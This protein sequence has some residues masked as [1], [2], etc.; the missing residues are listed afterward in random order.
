MAWDEDNKYHPLSDNKYTF[1]V[2]VLLTGHC[3]QSTTTTN[4]MMED[5]FAGEVKNY[6]V[7]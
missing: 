4:S 3:A 7:T 5:F 2:G 1:S 6:V